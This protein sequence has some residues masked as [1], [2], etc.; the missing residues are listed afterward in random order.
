MTTF[1]EFR[2]RYEIELMLESHENLHIG[3]GLEGKVSDAAILLRD[4]KPFIPG[5]SLRG[6]LRS[7]LERLLRALFAEPV[8]CTLFEENDG[9]LC[10]VA[11][12]KEREKIE[13][14][15]RD[16][17]LMDQWKICPVCQL[18]GSTLMAARL[19]VTDCR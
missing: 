5:S 16:A 11:N 4:G 7:A 19:K 2:N 15:D 14:G 18:F 8:G 12:E 17:L 6:V 3:S 9:N 10:V 1:L 13:R